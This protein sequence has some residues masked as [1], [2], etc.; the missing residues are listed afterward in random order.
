MNEH[1]SANQITVFSFVQRAIINNT[2]DDWLDFIIHASSTLSR[3]VKLA[4]WNYKHLI[5]AIL[6]AFVVGFRRVFLVF[7]T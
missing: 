1:I 3:V 7:L 2:D 5:P 4:A 6:L